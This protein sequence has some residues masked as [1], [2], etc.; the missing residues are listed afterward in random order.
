MLDII[1]YRQDKNL[2]LAYNNVFRQLKEEV[3]CFRDGDTMFLTPDYGNILDTYHNQYKQ[4]VLVCYIN[5][6]SPLST[7]QLYGGKINNDPNV[8]K[9]IIIA[10][11]IRKNLYHVTEVNQDISGTLMVVPRVVW[12]LHP[13]RE[14]GKCLGQDT[15]W[16]R[17]IRKAGIQILRM[18]GLYI[19]HS[20]RLRGG[21]FDKNHLA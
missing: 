2:G 14:D 3:I 11:T 7:G 20:Y 8:L 13:F 5:R 12:D 4:A 1:P 18:D 16:G 6:A 19:W 21:I 15:E 9:H 10:E 17:R